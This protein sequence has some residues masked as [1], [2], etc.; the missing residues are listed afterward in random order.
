MA[1]MEASPRAPT[2]HPCPSM[3][4]VN[5]A[6]QQKSKPV[7]LPEPRHPPPGERQGVQ[8][9]WAQGGSTRKLAK[10]CPDIS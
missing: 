6:L 3:D 2:P 9:L 7:P 5:W 4:S 1:I 10:K 8:R